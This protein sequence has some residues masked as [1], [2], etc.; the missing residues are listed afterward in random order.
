MVYSHC[1]PLTVYSIAIGDHQIIKIAHP[2]SLKPIAKQG[3]EPPF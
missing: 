3:A 1:L 2:H